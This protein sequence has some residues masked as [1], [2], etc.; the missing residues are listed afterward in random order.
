[1]QILRNRKELDQLLVLIRKKYLQIGLIPTMGSI[2]AGHLSLVKKSIQNKFFS[3][4]TI[5]INPTQFNDREDYLNYPK[6]EK[7]DIEKLS[8]VNCDALY[9]P[10]QEEMYPKG[11]K[12]RKTVN[13]FRN[14]LCDKFRPGH[15]EG[16]TTAVESLLRITNPD[17]VFLGEKDFQQLKIIQTL[18]QQLK[19][20]NV[21]HPCPSVCLQNGMSLSSRFDNFSEKD[22][23]VFDKCANQI[24]LL[25]TK[26]KNDINKVNLVDFKS[27]LQQQGVKKIEYL[28]IRNEENLS[29]SKTCNKSRLF[30][31]MYVGNVRVIDNFILY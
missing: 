20:N 25:I 21:I 9:F 6:E 15:F 4:A 30:I 8:A 7:K 5:Y 3:L 27:I 13:K 26:L 19:L 24:R 31:A 11:L 29:F 14:I 22:R 1:M 10:T 16:V 23:N 2:H 18:S 17:H 28:E 12:S